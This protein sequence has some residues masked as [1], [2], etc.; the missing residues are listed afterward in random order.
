M[1][2]IAATTVTITIGHSIPPRNEF[3]QKNIWTCHY[4]IELNVLKAQLPWTVSN[5]DLISI[6]L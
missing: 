5:L 4:G 1:M 3:C 6:A 2:T